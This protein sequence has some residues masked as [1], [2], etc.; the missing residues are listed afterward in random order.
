MATSLQ[1]QV[2]QFAAAGGMFTVSA[3]SVVLT[4][5]DCGRK[6]DLT[7]DRTVVSEKTA[8]LMAL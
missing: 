8:S 5:A 3:L 2:R 1:L 7:V 6:H 4:V